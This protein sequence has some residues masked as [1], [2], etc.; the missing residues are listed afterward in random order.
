M[1]ERL[2]S[3]SC[4]NLSIYRTLWP[5]A[6]LVIMGPFQN[7]SSETKLNSC[8]TL[9]HFAETPNLPQ[10]EILQILWFVFNVTG[11]FHFLIDK[12]PFLK[13]SR[14]PLWG[15][16][17]FLLGKVS[18]WTV[19]VCIVPSGLWW[20]KLVAISHKSPLNSDLSLQI[21]NQST[22]FHSVYW[23]HLFFQ[24]QSLSV[25]SA[26]TNP[27]PTLVI[28]FTWCMHVIKPCCYTM[29]SV[30]T[31][32]KCTV[33]KNIQ[34]P[35]LH[36]AIF[37]LAP[38]QAKLKIFLSLYL[39]TEKFSSNDRCTCQCLHMYYSEAHTSKW[40]T[41]SQTH[42]WVAGNHSM[43]DILLLQVTLCLSAHLNTWTTVSTQSSLLSLIC[44]EWN[45]SVVS[46]WG[47][48]RVDKEAALSSQVGT[49]DAATRRWYYCQRIRKALCLDS[50]RY[51]SLLEF[52]SRLKNKSCF[53]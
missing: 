53:L 27:F 25:S 17:F 42:F 20:A 4:I 44:C 19:S 15:Q 43:W 6:F 9:L 23:L 46:Q 50:V 3:T 21:V 8:K 49:H 11:C 36:E 40:V 26:N 10:R 48:S 31:V 52:L 39:G 28:G 16:I 47:H 22:F 34:L 37:Q 2:Y 13:K 5:V 24:Q 38:D 51:V 12:I 18:C 29:H 35:L 14:L 30:G 41:M 1:Q 45:C 33:N 32:L 7:W